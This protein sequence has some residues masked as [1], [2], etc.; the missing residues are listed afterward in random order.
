MLNFPAEAD[1]DAKQQ[2]MIAI[3]LDITEV[4]YEDI[5]VGKEGAMQFIA[6]VEVGKEHKSRKSYLFCP[7]V[8]IFTNHTYPGMR[9]QG[10]EG[11]GG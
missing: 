1:V 7:S 3:A 9:Y 5:G 6:V 2:N 4:N 8:T 11:G 10:S